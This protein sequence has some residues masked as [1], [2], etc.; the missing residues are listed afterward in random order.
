M[1]DFRKLVSRH[2]LGRAL[3]SLGLA[4]LLLSAP[5][6]AQDGDRPGGERRGPRKGEPR[7][8]QR[9]DSRPD[10]QE[11]RKRWK[12][13]DHK[14]R[15]NLNERYKSLREMEP[16]RRESRLDRA[17][18]LRQI[19]KEVYSA[20]DAPTKAKLDAMEEGERLRVLAGLALAEAR[21]RSQKADSYLQTPRDRR[22]EP[23]QEQSEQFLQQTRI[24]LKAFR[25]EKGLPQGVSAEQWQAL[26]ALEGREF[27]GALRRLVH[28]HPELRKELPRPPWYR[29]VSKRERS[30]HRAHRIPPEEHMRLMQ[31]PEA[32][33]RTQMDQGL[34]TRVLETMRKTPDFQPE[35]VQRV[36]AMSTDDFKTWLRENRGRRSGRRGGGPPHER[37][38]PGES[39]N[40]SPKGDRGRRGP[41]GRP[42]PRDKDRKRPPRGETKPKGS[43]GGRDA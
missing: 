3:L 4:V 15:H 33:R 22:E 5:A 29:E 38:K 34:R 8:E 20:I 26:M 36:E 12:S 37:G 14:E 13:M 41:D 21:E 27:G 43:P 25:L 2:L 18:R 16:K 28:S 40:P 24:S 32:Q 9:H 17:R 23:S 11:R 7:A 30:L 39:G 19:M 31:L 10:W 1:S 6:F 35:E 42:A